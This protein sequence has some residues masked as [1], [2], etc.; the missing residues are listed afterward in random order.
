MID[1][2]AAARAEAEEA[3]TREVL[4]YVARIQARC[5]DLGPEMARCIERA[6]SMRDSA[7]AAVGETK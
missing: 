1:Y 7:R 3:R 2:T 6:D 5:L 4:T